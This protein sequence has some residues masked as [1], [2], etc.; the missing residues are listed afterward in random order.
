MRAA[1]R[2]A[3]ATG[4]EVFHDTFPPRLERGGARPRARLLPYIVELA[5]EALRGL[6]HLV[7]VGHATPV[8]FFAYPG[9]PSRLA[10]PGDRITVLAGPEEDAV[11]AL[12]ALADAVGAPASVSVAAFGARRRCRRAARSTCRPLPPSIGALLPDD[13][14]V[15]DEAVT[16]SVFIQDA[17]MGAG[18][19]DYLYL[20]GGAIGWG[21][22]TATGAAVGAPGRPVVCA[23]GRRV[24]DVHDPGVVDAGEGGT[25]RDHDHRRQ[26]LVRDP[27]VRVPARRRLGRRRRPRTR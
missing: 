23:G 6:D 20:T 27:R 22:P 21:L 2:I 18:E 7:I 14:I 8:G 17:T 19:H 9:L 10:D 16:A 5:L 26:P 4:A 15:V 24:G 3:A 25:G 1:A 11:A 12:E 13:A